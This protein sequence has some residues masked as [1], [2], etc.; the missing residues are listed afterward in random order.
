MV[1][2]HFLN[3][4]EGSADSALRLL[5]AVLDEKRKVEFEKSLP[6]GYGVS[7]HLES[8]G[9]LRPILMLSVLPA[10]IKIRSEVESGKYAA[11]SPDLFDRFVTTS[12]DFVKEED[13][14][15]REYNLAK[16]LLV[17]PTRPD[18][19]TAIRR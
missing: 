1:K 12:K 18:P 4:L 15:A 13:V 11:T 2:A 9:R 14:A 7:V 10:L 19:E 17:H 16:L 3:D 6:R 8:A 5:F